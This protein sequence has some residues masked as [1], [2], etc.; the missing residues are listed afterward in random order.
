MCY[1]YTAR[2]EL[3]LYKFW[4]WILCKKNLNTQTFSIHTRHQCFLFFFFCFVQRKNL[5][6]TAQCLKQNDGTKTKK[7]NLTTANNRS[8]CIYVENK[9][10][11]RNKML[12]FLLTYEEKEKKINFD[13]CTMCLVPRFLWFSYFVLLLFIF[14]CATFFLFLF[15]SFACSWSDLIIG[16]H[17][18]FIFVIFQYL[19][20]SFHFIFT[21]DVFV[22]MLSVELLHWHKMSSFQTKLTTTNDIYIIC[23]WNLNI[24]PSIGWFSL[25][26][27]ILIVCCVVSSA[28]FSAI[29]IIIS[30]LYAHKSHL[31]TNFSVHLTL[32]TNDSDYSA[33]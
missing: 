1:T 22:C 9:W 10:Y 2:G 26:S 15:P 4:C 5:R 30:M 20:Y 24:H 14:F 8:R 25:V 19:I 28:L 29:T 11:T 12:Q 17:S 21:V 13:T 16:F 6:C 33:K 31:Y 32:N 27:H 3:L 23:A 18:A 7:E